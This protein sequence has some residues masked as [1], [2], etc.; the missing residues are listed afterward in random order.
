MDDFVKFGMLPEL[1]GRLPIITTLTDLTE[2]EMRRILT[3]PRNALLKQYEAMFSMDNQKLEVSDEAIQAV[4][5]QAM[6]RNTGARGLRGVVEEVFEDIMFES[7]STGEES[8]LI[9]EAMVKAK[10]DK[11][12]KIAA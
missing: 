4:V 7:P 10:F 1:M 6:E 2:D 8:I 11:T 5:L 12:K 9:N 3:E